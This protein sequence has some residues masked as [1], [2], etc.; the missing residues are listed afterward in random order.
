MVPTV[1]QHDTTA[2]GV[3]PERLVFRARDNQL[4]LDPTADKAAA[5][6][7]KAAI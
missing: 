2:I 5:S 1:A 7:N 3:G 4:S 6:A